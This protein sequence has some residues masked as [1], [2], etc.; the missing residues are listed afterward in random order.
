MPVSSLSTWLPVPSRYAVELARFERGVDPRHWQQRSVAVVPLEAG[1][2][3]S[4]VAALVA[5]VGDRLT[6]ETIVGVDTSGD[7]SLGSL[8][9]AST[10]GDLGALAGQPEMRERRSVD[11]FVDFETVTSVAT[12]APNQARPVI[13]ADELAAALRQLKRRFRGYVVDV[14]STVAAT[15]MPAAVAAADVVV[16]VT[17]TRRLPDWVFHTDNPLQP[18]LRSGNLVF[19]HAH[20]PPAAGTSLPFDLRVPTHALGIELYPDGRWNLP[21]TA[22]GIDLAAGDYQLTETAISLACSVYGR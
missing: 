11:R 22:R 1:A 8:L 21:T 15:L 6:H 18:F 17:S 16:A 7:R 20:Q 13:S 9:G 12:I 3:T 5:L 4:V 10:G 2:P 19:V 14:P